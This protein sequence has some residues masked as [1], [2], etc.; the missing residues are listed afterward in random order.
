MNPKQSISLL[1][2]K[3]KITILRL[4]LNFIKEENHL[5]CASYHKISN[6]ELELQ[7]LPLT[8]S[9]LGAALFSRRNEVEGLM[10]F[11]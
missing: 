1:K 10:D 5:L 9:D 6:G 2:W 4:H 11:S 7:F 8:N 3:G